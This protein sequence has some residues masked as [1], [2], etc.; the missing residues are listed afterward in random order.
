MNYANEW[1]K[2]WTFKNIPGMGHVAFF[3]F[4]IHPSRDAH[5]FCN[6]C[7]VYFVKF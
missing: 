7:S 1:Y 2:D 5:K 6:Q 3:S 4:S